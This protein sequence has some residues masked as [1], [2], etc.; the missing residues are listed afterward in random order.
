MKVLQINTTVNSGS[1]GRIAEEIGKL[2]IS[3]GE[4]SYIAF[5]R[6][7][8]DSKSN[9]IKIGAKNDF[10]SHV[11]FTRLF[12]R[13]GFS[14]GKATEKFLE[15]VSDIQPDIIHLHN[16]HGYYL[17][18]AVLFDFLNIIN[19][20]VIWTLHDC[21]SFTGHCAH[22]EDINCTKWQ[23]H[24]K[25]CPKVNRYPGSWWI[26]NSF[27]NFADKRQL[28]TSFRNLHIVVPSKWL[29]DLVS[30][31]FLGEFPVS[32]VYNGVDVNT[33][34]PSDNSEFSQISSPSIEGKNVI[35]GVA[36]VWQKSKGFDDFINLS[37]IISE[38]YVI[39]LVG[40]TPVQLKGLPKNIIGI[41]RT[42]SPSQ[43]ACWYSVATS[44]VNPTWSDNFPTTNLEALA[45]G[46]PVITY[47]TGGSAEA[48]NSETGYV[49]EKG[50]INGLWNAIQETEKKGK[51]FYN[52][53]CRTRALEYFNKKDRFLEYLELYQRIINAPEK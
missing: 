30:K 8:K 36:N 34:Q 42:E 9:K 49:V 27:K 12:D 37:K 48:I 29:R 28:F 24:C 2:L 21:W 16:I 52:I 19:K 44:F 50:N 47:Q 51:A 53:T 45:C 39:V 5:G 3:K 18:I 4:E 14:S 40:L 35:L 26:D 1:T 15:I 11:L 13:H 33:F 41:N 10:Y 25:V 17:N 46:T 38:N 32:V 31:S 20:P 7:E 6:E 23:S 22:F 43:L